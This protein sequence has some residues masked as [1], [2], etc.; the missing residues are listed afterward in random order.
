V[1][2]SHSD[3]RKFPIDTAFRIGLM[4]LAKRKIERDVT[5]HG[6]KLTSVEYADNR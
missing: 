3:G 6:D 4:I 2:A 5:M 1:H